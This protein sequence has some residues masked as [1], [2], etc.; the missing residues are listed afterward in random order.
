MTKRTF[1][2]IQQQIAELQEQAAS[3]RAKEKS[4]AIAQVKEVI[5]AFDIT[6]QELFGRA[7]RAGRTAKTPKAGGAKYGD[8]QGNTWGG[9]GPRPQWLREQLE[10][11][12][13]LEE[14]LLNGAGAKASKPPKAASARKAATKSPR[15]RQAV[16]RGGKNPVRYA[17]GLG[18]VWSGKGRRPGWL[19]DAIESGKRLE[20]FAV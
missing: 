5:A 2:Q 9:R 17:D 10:S 18:S 8:G 11:G 4:G 1:V 14:F 19:N 3:L 12:R 15:S 7:A 6:A 13:A 16:K 20:E